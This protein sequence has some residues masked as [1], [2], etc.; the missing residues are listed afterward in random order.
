MHALTSKL[1]LHTIFVGYEGNGLGNMFRSCVNSSCIRFVQ[2]LS[3]EYQYT[4]DKQTENQWQHSTT[5]WTAIW[6]VK[7]TS[8]VM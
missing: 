8:C 1:L 2:A 5:H 7:S 3:S 6:L 4:S